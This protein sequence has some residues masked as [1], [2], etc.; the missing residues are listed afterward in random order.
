MIPLAQATATYTSGELAAFLGILSFLLGLI[1]LGRKVFGHEPPLHRE[2][3]S[4]TDAAILKTEIDKVDHERRTSVANMHAKCD[5]QMSALRGEL[6]AKIEKLEIR[7][8]AV[9]ERTIK[10][11]RETKDLL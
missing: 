11:L 6:N 9:P 3:A 1:V 2:Y 7:I 10:L 5:G 8:D 4:R